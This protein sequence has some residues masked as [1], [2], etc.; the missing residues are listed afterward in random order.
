MKI[1]ASVSAA[2]LCVVSATAPAWAENEPLFTRMIVFGDSLSDPG[3]AFI[4][5]GEQSVPP[6]AELEGILIPSAPYAIGGHHF[7]NGPTWIEQLARE[8]LLVKDAEPALQVTGAR[9]YAFGGARILDS[10]DNPFDLPEQ[11]RLFLY[12]GG[13]SLLD[14]DTLIVIFAGGNDL[15]QALLKADAGIVLAAVDAVAGVH[16][17]PEDPGVIQRLYNAGGR[18]FLVANAPNLGLAPAI[19]NSGEAASAFAT[20]LAMEFNFALGSQLAVLQEELEEI[21][22]V[23]FDVFVALNGAVAE[24]RFAN[25]DAACISPNMPPFHCLTPKDFLFWDG[26]HPTRAGHEVLKE[27]ALVDLADAQL[28]R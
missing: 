25:A 1:V 17:P 21:Q 10:M 13:A 16:P 7:S 12:A 8:L 6:Y 27:R 28:V 4:A 26:I 22:V 23:T 24:G 19:R 9:N 20:L 18:K 2:V 5:T 11:V 3:N 14:E 15:R